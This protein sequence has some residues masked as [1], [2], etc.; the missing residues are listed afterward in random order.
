MIK[1]KELYAIGNL[2]QDFI[3]FIGRRLII[4]HAIIS[5]QLYTLQKSGNALSDDE[6]ANLRESIERD[7]AYIIGFI[8]GIQ[9]VN[10]LK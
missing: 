4:A 6:I 3:H 9:L 5:P 7:A 8:D 10:H 2:M 1:I